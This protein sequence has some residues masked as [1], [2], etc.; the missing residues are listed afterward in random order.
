MVGFVTRLDMGSEEKFEE[1]CQLLNKVLDERRSE[2]FQLELDSREAN[3]LINILEY[4][5]GTVNPGSGD[6]VA[7]ARFQ[8]PHCGSSEIFRGQERNVSKE[9]EHEGVEVLRIEGI[10]KCSNCLTQLDFRKFQGIKLQD[11]TEEKWNRLHEEE[12]QDREKVEMLE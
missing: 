8:C 12:Y 5:R 10:A 3:A 6:V 7:T 9:A 4:Y 11:Y 2:C 1:A